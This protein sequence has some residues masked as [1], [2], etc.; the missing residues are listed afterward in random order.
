[1]NRGKDAAFITGVKFIRGENIIWIDVDRTYSGDLIPEM[2]K[3]L[4]RYNVVVCSR[5][6][7]RKKVPHFNRIENLIFRNMIKRICGFKSYDPYSRL[8]SV[9]KRNLKT[10]K[11][12]S[13]SFG[14]EPEISIKGSRMNLRILG[15]PIE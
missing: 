14:I 1:M 8:Y 3:A 6:Y 9:N 13:R 5:K 11:L 7:G 10:M 2:V 15:I 4:G 12:T